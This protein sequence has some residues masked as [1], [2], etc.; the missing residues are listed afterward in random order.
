MSADAVAV[1]AAVPDE[2]RVV[3]ALAHA[4]PALSVEQDGD[5]ALHLSGG[6]GRY[7]FTVDAPVLVRVEGEADRLLGSGPPVPCPGWWVEV[8]ADPRVPGAP[9]AA[10]EF[11]R[12]LA[13]LGEGTLWA[14]R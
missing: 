1:L 2:A 8:R 5:G 7:W 10:R 9:E 4:V 11:A 13:Q 3:A 6:D 12:A 14:S